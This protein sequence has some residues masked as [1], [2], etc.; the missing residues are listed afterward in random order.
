MTNQRLPQSGVLF[1]LSPP[2]A[3]RQGYFGLL[4]MAALEAV[5]AMAITF[6]IPRRTASRR[7]ASR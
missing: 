7:L 5:E 2:V 3:E 4:A 1:A 6:L